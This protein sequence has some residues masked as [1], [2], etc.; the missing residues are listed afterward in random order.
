MYTKN[1]LYGK[2]T[3]LKCL[4]NM[5]SDDYI[6]IS[7]SFEGMSREAF[8]DE[9]T[10]SRYFLRLLYHALKYGRQTRSS[11]IAEECKKKAEEEHGLM[12]F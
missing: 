10:F 8:S 4:K 6:V 5:L 1:T 2:T 7:I 9:N 11:K 12:S 3:T